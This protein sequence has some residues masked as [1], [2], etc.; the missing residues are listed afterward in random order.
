MRALLPHVGIFEEACH[1]LVRQH[2]VIEDIHSCLHCRATAQPGVERV[3]FR[4]RTTLGCGSH[5]MAVAC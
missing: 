5:L 3:A 1:A 2:L 4:C